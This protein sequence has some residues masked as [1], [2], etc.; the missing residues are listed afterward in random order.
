MKWYGKNDYAKSLKTF[1]KNLK[2]NH[3]I[4]IKNSAIFFK[5]RFNF[6]FYKII[7]YIPFGWDFLVLKK[8]NFNN[9]FIYFYVYSSTYFFLLPVVK[10]FLNLNY[11][12]QTSSLILKFQFNNNFHLLF[13]NIFKTVFYSFSKLFF[14]KLKFKGKGYYIFKNTRNTI[15]LQFGYSHLLYLY[16]FFITVKFLTKTTILMFGINKNNITL[17]SKSLFF[18]KPINIFTGKGIRFSRQI[19]YRKTGKVSSYR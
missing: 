7:F 9:N 8:N 11:D 10:N 6:N 4:K 2:K 17:S 16:S 5:N 14:K 15:A 19:I 18:I 13:W 1:N 3:N 12:T